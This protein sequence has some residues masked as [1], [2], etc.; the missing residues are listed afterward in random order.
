MFAIEEPTVPVTVIAIRQ[1]AL[2]LLV[3]GGYLVLCRRFRVLTHPLA[4]ATAV[5][6]AGVSASII[7][8][9]ARSGWTEVPAVAWR[10]TVGSTLWGIFIGGAYWAT[11]WV[12]VWSRSR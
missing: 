5:I 6:V 12:I 7:G 8:A 11:R 9:A 2:L 4:V 3:A 1:A 10:S